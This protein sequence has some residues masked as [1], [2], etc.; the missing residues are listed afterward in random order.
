M[1]WEGIIASEL[2][3]EEEMSKLTAGFA[4]RMCKRDAASEG[5]STPIFD[6]KHQKRS[7]LDEEA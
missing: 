7:S 3:E 5:E 4:T 6:D 1:D 2:A